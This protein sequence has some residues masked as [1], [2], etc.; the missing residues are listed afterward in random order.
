EHPM[1][2]GSI[3][4]GQGSITCRFK[5]LENGASE[6][7]C[8]CYDSQQRW[9]TC[10]HVVATGLEL[11]KRKA[12]QEQAGPPSQP[13]MTGDGRPYLCRELP[14]TAGAQ[15]ARLWLHLPENWLTL[16]R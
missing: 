10:A 2:R 13:V 3:K 11:L 9:I 8:P 4:Y 15:P 14:G 12:V 6:N 16:W 5:L 7:L 1:V